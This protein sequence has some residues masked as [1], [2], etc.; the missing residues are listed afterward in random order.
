MPLG[1]AL[2]K[3]RSVRRF[4]EKPVP[5]EI[6]EAAL[7]AA[8]LAPSPHGTRPW[9][10]CVLDSREAKE[11]LARRMGAD[12]LRDMEAEGVPE[13]E[14]RR[15]HGGSL[16]LLTRAPALVLASLSYADLDEYEEAE[17]QAR[18][19]MMA[20]HSLGG[21]LQSLMLALA[22]QGVASVWRCAP[23]FCPETARKA[24]DLPADW[25]PRALIAAGY[26]A[27][28]PAPRAEAPAPGAIVR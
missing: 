3:R 11:T 7:G 2:R 4:A 10:F 18:E 24:L 5:M 6:L 23:L 28:P 22:A 14:R 12:F 16:R 19:W 27:R 26:P 20:E 25:T 13:A 9:R 15:R 21:A 8:R 17:K 1:E